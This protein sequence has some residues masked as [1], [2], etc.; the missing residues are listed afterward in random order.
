M[1]PLGRLLEAIP[2]AD[3]DGPVD[4]VAIAS[5]FRRFTQPRAGRDVCC[6]SRRA[7]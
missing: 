1:I 2:D 4:G 5:T 6:H 3:V 7:R